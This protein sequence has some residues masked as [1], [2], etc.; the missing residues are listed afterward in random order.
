MRAFS[1]IAFLI[2]IAII[3]WLA[4]KTLLV[5]S[6]GEGAST[7]PNAPQDAGSAIERAEQIRS[8]DMQRQMQQQKLADY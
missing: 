6:G 4:S 1:F 5:A 7:H 2:T 8:A 3:G